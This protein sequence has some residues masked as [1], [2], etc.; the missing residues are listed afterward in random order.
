MNHAGMRPR[1]R[2]LSQSG[3]QTGEGRG[4]SHRIT[5]IPR[6]K[7]PLARTGRRRLLHPKHD[8]P[9]RSGQAPGRVHGP[10]ERRTT[11]VVQKVFTSRRTSRKHPGLL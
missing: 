4:R 9:Y 10:L 11:Q 6:E 2:L 3:S 5:P 7:I 8:L 1:N